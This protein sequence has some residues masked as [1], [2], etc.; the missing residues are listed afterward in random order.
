[1]NSE[2]KVDPNATT[3]PM[4]GGQTMDLTQNRSGIFG[5]ID[6]QGS[7]PIE[8]TEP[9]IYTSTTFVIGCYTNIGLERKNNEDIL[10]VS[11]HE[12]TDSTTNIIAADGMGAYEDGEIAAQI[13]V[14][15]VGEGMEAGLHIID[16][17]RKASKNMKNEGLE[18][19]SGAVYVALQIFPGNEEHVYQSG[20]CT[21]ISFS[22]TGDIE[23]KTEDQSVAGVFK[24]AFPNDPNIDAIVQQYKHATSTAVTA[25][26]PGKTKIYPS[27][28][29]R[30]G[31]FTIGGS[32]GFFENWPILSEIYEI[33]KTKKSLKEKVTLLATLTR[34]RMVAHRDGQL[35]FGKSDNFTFFVVEYL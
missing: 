25:N 7:L 27:R 30:S 18:G 15:T 19:D 9:R 13:L 12:K 3:Q 4:Q 21:L 5:I 20:D 11:I 31:D 29:A 35:E 16:A 33:L 1:M 17:Q 32:D 24:A 10:F 23:F 2:K 34:A 28:Q 6:A 14:D 8:L 22:K 26:D